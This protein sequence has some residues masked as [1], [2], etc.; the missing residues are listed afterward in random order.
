M[1]NTTTLH[2]MTQAQLREFM[3]SKKT[4]VLDAVR[5]Y[6]VWDARRKAGTHR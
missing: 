3:D 2:A 6:K 4:P 1:T 5:A